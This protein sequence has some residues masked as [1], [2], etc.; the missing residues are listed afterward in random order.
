MRLD[1]AGLRPAQSSREVQGT[2]RQRHRPAARRSLALA[3]SSCVALVTAER[4]A[5]AGGAMAG[6]NREPTPLQPKRLLRPQ[7]PS[8]QEPGQFDDVFGL[9]AQGDRLAVIRTDGTTFARI[10][11]FDLSSGALEGTA[12]LPDRAAVPVH[13]ELLSRGKGLILIAREKAD[14]AA[15][16]HAFRIS[17]DG[18]VAA[19]LGPASSFG[20]PPASAPQKTSGERES[21]TAA[22][23]T[24]PPLIA[25]ERKLGEHGA[26][27]SYVVSA[28]DRDTFRPIGKPRLHTTD[29]N[30]ILAAPPGATMIGFFDGYTR[31]LAMRAS[32]EPKGDALPGGGGG[33]GAAPGIDRMLVLDALSGRA[34]ADQAIAEPSTWQATTR[35]RLEHPGRSVFVEL[36]PDGSGVDVVDSMGRK[37]PLTPIVPFRRYDPKN[38]QVEEDPSPTSVTFALAI[39]PANPDAIKRRRLDL[40]MLDIY[41][42]RLSDGASPGSDK[43]TG[44]SPATSRDDAVRETTAPSTRAIKWRARIFTPRPVTWRLRAHTLAVLKRQKSFSRGGDEIQIF[45][46]R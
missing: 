15:P 32:D 31:L 30:G 26:E 9:D 46:L 2:T 25:F 39:D 24:M 4:P 42:A 17:A 33:A 6:G 18:A 29:A 12:P 16:V 28:F 7:D 36:N 35:L 14:E 40:P 19:R 23:K 3:L 5:T 44:R 43:N 21:P 20:W 22:P 45:D 34:I 1:E 13:L 38:V 11:T 41:T 27:A 37:A 8:G 10:E